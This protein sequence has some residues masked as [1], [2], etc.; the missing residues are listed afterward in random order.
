MGVEF[1]VIITARN[2]EEEIGETI[3]NLLRFLNLE[4][5][6]IVVVNDCSEDRTGN[7]L[8]S[9]KDEIKIITNNEVKGIS[10]S[11]NRAISE[12]LGG[13]LLFLDAHI[14]I[15][16]DITTKFEKV[17][18]RYPEVLIVSGNY[19]VNDSTE[20][21]K[22]ILREV[23]RRNYRHKEEKGFFITYDKFTTLSS[24]ILA[25]KKEVLE[26]CAFPE[27]YIGCAAED[28]FFQLV[29]MEKGFNM[30]H[31]SSITI[32][33]RAG[34][35]T[36]DLLFNKAITQCKGFYRLISDCINENVKIPYSPFYLDYPLFIS[37]FL[38]SVP[39]LTILGIN[40]R[41]FVVL[42]TFSFLL[43]FFQLYKLFLD[44]KISFKIKLETLL[45]IIFNELIKI[46]Y[47]PIFIIKYKT[48]PLK[49][50]T[51]FIKWKINQFVYV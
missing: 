35:S 20:N 22:D 17:Y 45:Y 48:S 34:I 15:E 31:T 49:L 38:L 23:V 28:T 30:F 42:S 33:H 10:K 18:K 44:T 3:S 39:F 29:L 9:F 24:C 25:I 7:I 6:E 36:Q 13:C 1:S 50:L 26:H 11:R 51:I 41:V 14:R 27:E 46:G 19:L 2:E 16:S 40:I 43:D 32:N 12:S 5:T 37:I 8:S 47:L 4:K 21:D